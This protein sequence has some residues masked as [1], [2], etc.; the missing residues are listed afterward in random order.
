MAIHK[1]SLQNP[2]LIRRGGEIIKSIAVREIYAAAFH[3]IHHFAI[4]G[5]LLREMMGPENA[6]KYIP[7]KFGF[8][9]KTGVKAKL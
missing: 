6:E 1:S 8:K 9:P 4:I 2:I 5:V 3:A 7:H